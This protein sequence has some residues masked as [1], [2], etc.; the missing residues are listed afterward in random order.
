MEPGRRERRLIL[1]GIA[2]FFGAG[3]LLFVLYQLRAVLLI[4]YVSLLLAIGLNPAVRWFEHHPFGRK[5]RRVPRWAAVLLLYL[6]FPIFI[7]IVVAVIV[8]P[9]AAQMKLLGQHM[10]EYFDKT[11]AF[12]VQRGWISSELTWT[13]LIQRIGNPSDAVAGVLGAVQNVLGAIGTIATI[14]VLPYYLLV[15]ARNLQHGVLRLVVRENRDLVARLTANVAIKVGAWLNGQ[16]VLCLI[17]GTAVTAALWALGVPF[18]YV[19]GLVAGI[20]EAVPVLGPIIS[21]VPAVLVAGTVSINKAVLVALVF[22]GIQSIENNFLVP[23]VMQR[24]V[25]LHTVT[26]LVALLCG[27][28]LLGIVGALLAVPTAAILQVFVQEYLEG[29]DTNSTRQT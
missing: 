28:T 13:D 8:P 17:I 25:G 10:P 26:V 7:A 3:L 12:L 21:A 16:M 23:R 18:F 15:D 22:W 9:I 19:L 1:F 14:I 11:Q 27:S 20:G 4:L 2:S 24:Q 29:R 6:T 5:N